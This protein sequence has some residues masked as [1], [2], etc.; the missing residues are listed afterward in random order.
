MH[1]MMY[2]ARLVMGYLFFTLS[3]SA[4]AAASIEVPMHLVGEKGPGKL[5]GT[6]VLEESH[7]GVLLKP[8][9]HDLSPGV[10]GFHIHEKPSCADHGMAAGGHLDPEQTGEHHGPYHPVGH[11]GDLPVLVVDKQGNATLPVL[12]PRFS[13]AH[14]RGHA[15]MIHAGGDNYADVPEKLGG[16]GARIACGVID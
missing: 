10:H 4:I 8:A 13:L 9:L 14:L 16:G 5:I 12:A 3:S 11:L 15:L 6:V 7:C 2:Q 1:N